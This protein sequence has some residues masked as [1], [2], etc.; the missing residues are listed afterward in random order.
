[1]DRD[2]DSVDNSIVERRGTMT[3]LHPLTEFI[4]KKVSGTSWRWKDMDKLIRQYLTEQAEWL[5]KQGYEGVITPKMIDQA[6]QLEP[7][8]EEK[9]KII[10]LVCNNC[11]TV[12]SP[13]QPTV[14]LTMQEKPH[15]KPEPVEEKCQH[16]WGFKYQA[17]GLVGKNIYNH[18]ECIKC[19]QTKVEEDKKLFCACGQA[20]ENHDSRNCSISGIVETPHPNPGLPKLPEKLPE[21]ITLQD[22]AFLEGKRPDSFFASKINALIEYLRAREG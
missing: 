11:G 22:L 9:E 10:P 6:F 4:T 1:M 18:Y 5:R 12:L 21:K 17:P 16:V 8:E 20:W 19:P 7:V 2:S 15:P 3:K 14:T 13:E